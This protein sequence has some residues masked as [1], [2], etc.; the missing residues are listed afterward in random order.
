MVSLA[1]KIRTYTKYA[2]V[3]RALRA[4]KSLITPN[5]KGVSKKLVRHS[6]IVVG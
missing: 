4:L 6:L 3:Y 5:K 2:A 1:L